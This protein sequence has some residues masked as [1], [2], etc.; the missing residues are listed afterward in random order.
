MKIETAIDQIVKRDISN[1]LKISKLQTLA[2]RCY[3]S[4]PAQKMVTDTYKK[5]LIELDK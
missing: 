2:L 5:L 4:S 1:S 3:P